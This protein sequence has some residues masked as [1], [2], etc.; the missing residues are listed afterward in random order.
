MADPA[1]EIPIDT[2][3][4]LEWEARQP[5]RWEL[6]GGVVRMMAGGSDR[7]DAVSNNLRSALLLR[8]RGSGCRLRGPEMRVVTPAGDVAY[9]DAFVRCGDFDPSATSVRD[10]I[11]VFEVLSPGTAQFD[12][13]RKKRAYQTIPSLRALVYVVPEEPLL[14]VVR[15]GQGD[16][17][18]EELVEGTDVALEL[19]EI[20]TTVPL[21]EIYADIPMDPA[22]STARW[23]RQRP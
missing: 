7:H 11:V 6:V 19:P 1:L 20:G 12:L 18:R 15:R 16:S 5:E 8:L 9:P 4:F 10:P 14:L 17:W 21:S 2:E 13:T 23:L 22:A 3:G